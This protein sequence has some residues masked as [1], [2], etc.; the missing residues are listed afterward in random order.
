MTHPFDPETLYQLDDDG[1]IRVSRGNS[2]GVFTNEGIH[3]S[4]DL[5]QAD[6]QLC[7]WIGNVPDPGAAAG[8]PGRPSMAASKED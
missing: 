8:R 2:I 1:N 5:K 4:G 7:V 3:L 6:P